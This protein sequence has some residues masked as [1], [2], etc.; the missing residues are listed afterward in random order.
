MATAS[1]HRERQLLQQ[2]EKILL[3][4]IHP[5]LISYCPTMDLIAVVTD[6][7]NLDVYRING[8]RAFGLKRKDEDLNIIALQWE[9]N[10]K[11]IAVSWSDGS[12]DLVSAETGKITH[13]DVMLPKVGEEAPTQVKCM[14]WGLNFINVEAVKRRTG[15]KP[16]KTDGATPAKTDIFGHPTTED[17][18]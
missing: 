18:D 4:P 9:F 14:G 10:G 17:W 13:K 15:L 6:E 11:S 5:H 12:T 2:A 1:L 3:R 8:Q 7:E 16:N